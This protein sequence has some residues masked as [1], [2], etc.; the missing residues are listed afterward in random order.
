MI[1]ALAERAEPEAPHGLVARIARGMLDLFRLTGLFDR[2]TDAI[3]LQTA[4][5][6]R[7]V[8]TEL[9]PL[10]LA[11]AEVTRMAPDDRKSFEKHFANVPRS[12]R[13]A[14]A[15]YLSAAREKDGRACAE[16]ILLANLETVLHEQQQLDSTIRRA[17]DAVVLDGLLPLLGADVVK[18]LPAPLASLVEIPLRLVQPALTRLAERFATDSLLTLR[19]R[20]EELK[21]RD[22]VRPEAGKAEFPTDLA[23]PI[24]D[25]DLRSPPLSL[26]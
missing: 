11:L 23:D 4:D 24:A 7:L 25:R 14:F 9:A 16:H 1:S 15:R 8:F 17:L 26:G 3:S 20:G 19:V 22:D 2:V 10:F 6:N 12:L 18:Q 21:F 5:G 13:V